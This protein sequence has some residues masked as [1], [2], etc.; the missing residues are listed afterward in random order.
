[1]TWRRLFSLF[2]TFV[3]LFGGGFGEWLCRGAAGPALEI[4]SMA[5]DGK[6]QQMKRNGHFNLG[7]FPR[8]IEVRFGS[9]T[10]SPKNPLRVRY[11]LDGY[12]PSWREL[13]GEMF[14]VL[15]FYDAKGDRIAQTTFS[16]TGD[17]TGWTGS[18]MS[19]KFTHRREVVTAPDGASNVWVVITSAGPPAT[20]G[21]FVVDGLTVSK[22]GPGNR[23][24]MA[25]IAWPFSRGGGD[26]STNEEPE[27]WIRDGTRPSMAKIAELGPDPKA[28][29]LAIFDDDAF[30]HAEWHNAPQFAGPVT[31]GDKLV[32]EWNELFSMG[33]GDPHVVTYPTLPAGN[34]VFRLEEMTPWGAP[35]GNEASVAIDVPVPYWQAAWFWA[36]IAG[37]AV[38]GAL[39][40]VR[41][42]SWQR[43]RREMARLKYERA[44]E[45]ERIRIAR[46]I[47]DDVGARATQISLLSATART[48]IGSAAVTR[49]HLDRICNCSRE[50]ISALYEIVWAV[51]PEND[52][53]E[54]LGNYLCKMV[55]E[56]CKESRLRCRFEIPD[57]PKDIQISSQSRHSISMAT[58][59][60]VHNIVKHAKASEVVVRAAYVAPVLTITVCDNGGGFDKQTASA[61]YG[62]GNMKQRLESIGGTYTVTSS[63]TEGT[64]VIF[65]LPIHPAGRNGQQSPATKAEGLA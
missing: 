47:H 58:K 5:V 31:P 2:L 24:P 63:P 21:V 16:A 56:W 48:T 20:V 30:G 23:S 40:S 64:T 10:N 34:Y 11:R 35:T 15:R 60:A 9:A 38:L 29:A 52:N 41:Y 49:A 55:D 54:A 37:M 50:L 32:V 18:L 27:G 13:G 12:D 59:E 42:V 65:R 3:C 22:V 53:L 7:S 61:G 43:V 44:L 33:E 51:N 36:V 45:Q 46:D 62:L 1:M 39:G 6:L 26:Q 25:L 57:L 4:R 14:L 28:R 17:S 19:S 8:E